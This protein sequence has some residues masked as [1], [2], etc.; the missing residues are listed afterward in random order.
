MA[1]RA[2]ERTPLD[3]SSSALWCPARAED[4]VEQHNVDDNAER[5]PWVE[6]QGE[7]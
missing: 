3:L 7:Q 2:R 5:E 1:N 6:E 4:Q